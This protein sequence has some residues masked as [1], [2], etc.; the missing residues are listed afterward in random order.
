MKKVEEYIADCGDLKLTH[1]DV[2][3]SFKNG[4]GDGFYYVTI[5]NTENIEEV[6]FSNL[7][8]EGK[9][10]GEWDV[11]RYDCGRGDPIAHISGCNVVYS[12]R[13]KVGER[14][15]ATGNMVIIQLG[16]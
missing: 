11:E 7:A 5:V 9:V 15:I 4:I 8:W 16:K 2:A 3:V 14:Y 10:E 1:G 12:E 13:H 6:D